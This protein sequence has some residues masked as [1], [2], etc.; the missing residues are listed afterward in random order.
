[1]AKRFTDTNKYKKSFIRGLQGA[2]KLLW[3]YLY[4]DCDHS[5]IWIVDFEIAQA[6]LGPDMAISKDKA[7]NLF[8]Y[9]EQRIVELDGGKKWFL[10]GFIEFQYGL[11]SD[12]N[13]AH[14]SVISTLKKFNLLETDFT[15]KKIKPLT[16]PLQGAKDKDKE[17]DKEKE[18]EQ[19]QEKVEAFGILELYPFDE[20]WEMY[21]K[22]VG[23]SDCEKKF[24]KLKESEKLII[25]QKIND[26]V[27]STPNIQ[28]RMN[29]E[30]YLNGKHW[31]DEIIAKTTILNGKQNSK[32]DNIRDAA[33]E[34][35]RLI[36][37]DFAN[38]Y[39]ER[40][41]CD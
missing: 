24:S 31:N 4:H 25:W 23:R 32:H 26:Y 22:K 29:P 12:K 1:M 3:D 27:A 10:P 11:L 28:Y 36:A 33:S 14:N 2:Y 41:S 39:P 8:N 5:G 30:T 19:E 40:E 21:G 17:Q 34:A 13:R 6:Y 38:S 7:L 9:E 15:L 16:S 20:F 35:K 37:E 18:M